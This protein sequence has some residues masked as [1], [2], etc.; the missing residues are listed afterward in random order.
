MSSLIR[1]EWSIYSDSTRFDIDDSDGSITYSYSD[2]GPS[3]HTFEALPTSTVQ[4][5]SDSV[6]SNTT[7]FEISQNQNSFYST[8]TS[9][10]SSGYILGAL[11][12]L[13]LG[14]GTILRFLGYV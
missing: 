7:A 11:M 14:G 8:I 1:G 13:V 5:T 10:I 9:T 4:V 3:T 2:T 12:V 6:S